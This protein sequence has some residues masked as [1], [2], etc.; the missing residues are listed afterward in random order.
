MD[1]EKFLLTAL[2]VLSV[3]AIIGWVSGEYLWV[4][5]IVA[6]AGTGFFV[7]AYLNGRKTESKRAT[8][9]SPPEESDL[10]SSASH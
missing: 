8:K 3:V 1:T 7:S 9:H 4:T 6:I 2:S 5:K 10:A